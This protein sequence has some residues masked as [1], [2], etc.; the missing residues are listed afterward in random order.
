MTVQFRSRIRSIYDY[1]VEIK[2]EGKCC[3]PNGTSQQLTFLDC[4]KADGQFFQDP[5]TPCPSGSQKGYCCACSYLTPLQ[6]EQAIVNLPYDPG[7]QSSLYASTTIGIRSDVTECE[8]NRIGGNWSATASTTSE[9]CRRTV[10]IDGLSRTIDVRIPTACC[11]LLIEDN[12]PVGITCQNVCGARECANLALV[13]SGPSDPFFD[14]TYTPNKTCGVGIV[15]GVQPVNCD[16]NNIMS[17]ITTASNA[18]ADELFGPCYT[19]IQN[20]NEYSYD[21]SIT[22]EFSCSGYWVSPESI[23]STVAYC[24]HPYAPKAPSII[25]S[26]V[27]S[28]KYTQSEFDQLGL[29]PGDEFQGGIYIGTFKPLKTNSTGSTK[30]Y[31]SL[32]FGAP[33]SIYVNVTDESPDEKWAIIVNKSFIETPLLTSNDVN[34]TLN[35]SYYDGYLNSYGSA[36]SQPKINSTTVNTLSG[37]DR[38]GFIDYY[39]PSIVEMMYFAEQYRTNQILKDTFEFSGAFCSTSFF[40]DKYITQTP[41]GQSTFNNVN[42]LYGQNFSPNENFGKC[43]VFGINTNMKLMLFRRIVIT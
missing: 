3:F 19:L 34:V 31:G 43:M 42:F 20:N 9:F 28:T 26:F 11:S 13:E 25:N 32:N 18:F 8:C 30:V 2:K 23:D 14:T 5:D 21:C 29:V 10:I 33:Q 38:N 39:I 37:T 36:T 7:S 41:T 40:T 22:T 16:A 6:R 27:D 15:F 4:F 1:G 12:L 35:T 24:N 17:R